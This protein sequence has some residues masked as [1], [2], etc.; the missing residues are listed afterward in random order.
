MSGNTR[1]FLITSI[2]AGVGAIAASLIMAAVARLRV[3]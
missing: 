1:F 2:G 3:Q